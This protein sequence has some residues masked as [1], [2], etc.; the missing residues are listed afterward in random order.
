MEKIV[1]VLN[2]EQ[3]NMGTIDFA[4]FLARLSNST[5]TGF[6]VENILDYSEPVLAGETED[7]MLT[8]PTRKEICA[9]KIADFQ[10]ACTNRGV[11]FSTLWKTGDALKEIVAE[12]RFADM[13]VIDPE[14]S[15]A[16]KLEPA[17]TSFVK[18]LLP[19]T[20]CPVMI[21]PY[22]FEEIDEIVFAYDAARPSVYAIK[23]FSYLFPQLSDKKIT[24]LH[25]A[26]SED[27]FVTDKD[28]LLELMQMHYNK[29][30]FKM[31]IG[32]PA[33]ELFGYLIGR[34]NA[35][36]VMGAFGRTM[37]S[38]WFKASTA[39]TVIKA[40]NLPVFIAHH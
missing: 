8:R 29:I 16:N 9:H 20:E 28:R 32:K 13:L 18:S 11:R 38:G 17:P 5:L 39:E 34:K 21:A 15:F 1:L 26:E 2:A 31:L 6:F 22:S 19:K 37:L 35:M 7:S 10:T 40:T 27:R 25:V 36:V 4:C 30:G 3:I 24:V 14:L 12:S 23:L 33:D